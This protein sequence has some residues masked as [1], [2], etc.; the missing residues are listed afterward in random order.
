[1]LLLLLLLLLPLLLLQLLL[2]LRRQAV[3]QVLLH[4][5]RCDGHIAYDRVISTAQGQWLS[6]AQWILAGRDREEGLRVEGQDRGVGTS[7]LASLHRGRS[8]RSGHIRKRRST[9]RLERP[10]HI[11]E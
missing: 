2:L 11:R 4:L 9:L 5:G 1:M 8:C 3:A 10:G 7:L 6:R